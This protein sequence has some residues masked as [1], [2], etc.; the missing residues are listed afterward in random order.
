MQRF[1][2]PG[3]FLRLAAAIQPWAVA[4]CAAFTG[5]GLY[6]AL[7]VSPA[8][9]QHSET[10]RIMYVHVPGARQPAE[11]QVRGRVVEHPAPAGAAAAP[12]RAVDSSFDADAA[13]AD[14]ARLYEL[15]RRGADRAHARRARRAPPARAA[16]PGGKPHGRRR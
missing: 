1:A 9:Y 10:P 2:N 8:D 11:H 7:V 15:L 3:R 14:V 4:A 6:F 13:P 12:R 5:I 16:A